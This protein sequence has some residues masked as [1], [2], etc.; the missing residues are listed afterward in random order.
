LDNPREWVAL[1]PNLS[2]WLSGGFIVNLRDCLANK[3]VDIAKV[4]VPSF[5]QMA[6]YVSETSMECADLSQVA[7]YI[8]EQYGRLGNNIY[9]ILHAIIIARYLGVRII[10]CKFHLRNERFESYIFD[11]IILK[12]GIREKLCPSVMSATFFYPYGFERCF[13]EMDYNVVKSDA[14]RIGNLYF[15][16]IVRACRGKNKKIAFHFRSGDIFSNDGKVHPFYVQPPL[17]Y[18]IL[19]LYFIF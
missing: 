12:F 18:Y 7:F 2:F 4:L 5:E 3:G 9:Q 19:A 6:A 14:E 16:D 8:Q 11:N 10:D 17:S 15:K 13:H 1:A